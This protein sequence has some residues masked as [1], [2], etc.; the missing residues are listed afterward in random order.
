MSEQDRHQFSDDGG[1]DHAPPSAAS[2]IESL[3]AFG[4]DL[5]T[6]IADLVD[7]SVTAGARR[8]WID[9]HWAGNES[10]V[11]IADDGCGM[12]SDVLV[13]AMH[14]GSKN[15]LERRDKHDLGRFGLGLKTAS[16]SQC[17]CLTVRSKIEDQSLVTR[18]W[19]LDHVARTNDWQL[20]RRAN[21]DGEKYLER[22]LDLRSGTV[23]LWQNL[24]RVTGHFTTQNDRQQ[25]S[26]L[27]LAERVRIHLGMVFQALLSARPG[28]EILINDRPIPAWDPF[29][30]DQPATQT[31]PVTRLS[32]RGEVVEVQPFILPHQSK[33]TRS[34]FEGAA[35]PRGW[36][37]HQGFYVYRNQR[38]LVPG[39]WLGFGWA[40]EEHYK[41]ARIRIEIP[42]A[43]DH[44][45]QIDV[46]K[47]RAIPPLPLREELHRIGARARADAK[48]IYSH[49][50]AKLVSTEDRAKIF[51]WEPISRHDKTFYR[52]N[53]EH[54]LFKRVQAASGD[55]KAFTAFMRLV[56]ETVPIPHITIENSERPGSHAAPFDHAREREIREIMQQAY[57]SLVETGYGSDEAIRRLQTI[58][59]FELFPALLQSLK[60]AEAHG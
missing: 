35:G 50:G 39:D 18:R 49:R 1:Y 54:P 6:A 26:F 3:R 31:L 2:L 37:A 30:A 19:D 34:E 46:T 55:K 29:L 7:N 27:D 8:I 56:E 38:L 43:L 22:I 16:F 36:N 13:A 53:R 40:K 42:N 59:P 10:A 51:M 41:L 57:D 48:R 32:L 4:Y 44:D 17:R 14:L 58:W 21:S 11:A 28:I 23:V 25:Q 12:A 20:L 24:D 15:P 45:W 47:S 52:L 33:I 9:F 5:P 60:E